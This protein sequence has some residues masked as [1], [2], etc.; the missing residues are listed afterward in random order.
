MPVLTGIDVLGIQRFVFASNRLRDVVTGSFLVHWSTSYQGALFGLVAE[1]NILLAGGGN[2]I[3]EFNSLDNENALDKAKAFATQYTRLIYDEV[4]GLEVVLVHETYEK[5]TLACALKSLQVKLAM[6]KAERVP[7]VPLSGLSVTASCMETGLPAM[8]VDRAEKTVTISRNIFNRR[9]KKGEADRYWEK[10]LK[11]K[12]RYDFPLELD[13]LGR[14]KGDTSLIGIVHVDGN[15]VGKKIKQWLDNASN[16]DQVRKEYKEWSQAIDL[17]GQKVLQV[18]V[19]RIYQSL[20]ITSGKVIGAPERLCFELESDKGKQILPIRPILLGG[21]DLTFVCDGRLALDLAETA[22]NEFEH[23]DIPHLGNITACAGIAIV[24]VHSPFARGYDLA[25]KL[26]GS[27]KDK[28]KKENDSGC[29]L[30]WH[31]GIARPGETVTGIRARQYRST[32]SYQLT[33]RPYRLGTV[34]EDI[35]ET[36]RWLSMMLLDD[37]NCGLRGGV[38]SERR[39]K[40]KAVAELVRDGPDEVLSAFKAWGVVDDRLQLPQPIANDGFISNRTPLLDA[41]EII[42][43]HLVL[44]G[45]AA[46]TKIVEEKLP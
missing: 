32:N 26:C 7:S 25:E 40:V 39:N 24:R 23:S 16:D 46:M 1:G 13:K 21:D 29:A 9:K 45:G 4:P 15:G 6:A 30:D 14:D 43:L 19:D 11:N 42:D 8:Q 31:I 2:A 38:W 44:G 3:I 34:K 27:A 41:V 37:N 12:E 20:E 17:F 35:K 22:L 18:V 36:W 28:L 5:G 10:Y 33:C